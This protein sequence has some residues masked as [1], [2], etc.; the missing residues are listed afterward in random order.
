MRKRVRH[1][2]VLATIASVIGT[3]VSSAVAQT[4]E[5]SVYAADKAG[6]KY[7]PLDQI[8][9]D[10][11][12]DLE[13][14]WRQPV[15]PDEIR[16]GET[17][18]GPVGSQTT[19]LMVDGLLYFS[20]GLGTITAL[21]PTTGEVVW[22]T[23][24]SDGVR[25]RQTRG[26]AYWS[27][28]DERRV[29]A[30][31][32]PKLV[33]LNA[34]TGERDTNFGEAGEVDLREGLLRPFPE[35]Y[36]NSAPTIIRDVIIIGSFIGDILNN[37][38]P[39]TKQAP[40]GD[41]RGYD[42]RTGE[43]LWT[44]YT[45]PRE[46][47]F[48]VDTWGIDPV[49]DRPSWEYSGNTN[50]WAHPTGDEELGIVY[51]PL[52][53][54][55]NDYYGGHR[56]GDNLFAES[57][58]AVDV[59]TGERLWHFQA[60]HHGVWD[61]DFASSAV[62]TDI[63]VNGREIKAV[64][65]P[66]KQAWVYVFDRVT[67]EPVWP[68][69]ERPVP[70]SPVPGERLAETQPFPTKPPAFELQGVTVDDLIDFTPELRAEALEIL[71][72]YEWGPIFTPPVLLDPSPGG[73]KGTI[74]SPGTAGG[75]NW[76]GAGFDPATGM[77]Y[78]PSAY[79]QNVIA[80][81]PSTNPR[82]DVRFV[83]ER[84]EPLPGPQGLPLFKPPY[85]RLTAIDL[86]TGDISWQVPNGIG[87]RNHPA[88]AHLDLPPLGNPGRASV[89]VTGSL[90]FLGEGGNTG[91]SSLPQWYNGP[92]GKMFRAYDKATGDVVW[93]MELPG[94]TSGAPMTYMIDGKQY[95]IATV[96]WDDMGSEL[97]ALTLP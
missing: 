80:I 36:W 51:L 18:R 67:G 39:A 42:V 78:V 37:Q 52:S 64:A 35:Y 32:G 93:E 50:M 23:G 48:G 68:I 30:T 85:G 25:V 87:P 29:V 62:L 9:R 41:V 82:S 2:I 26:V 10:N 94:G 86:N 24:P 91:V 55:S 96:G 89:L 44:F 17:T 20:S 65:Q 66:S 61:Y 49:E 46:N 76:S 14:A 77:L 69:E 56:P 70:A 31:L 88:I 84:Y 43:H 45:I 7:L 58:V 47:E 73:K 19:P 28:G 38:M 27:D 54:P 4:A 71:E 72:R 97:V 83:R 57:L 6:T 12:A 33:S 3:T 63:T 59:E 81:T 75:A 13:I 34:R 16:N 60:I 8:N 21:A 92:G 95:I 90:V 1:A 53:T 22:N 15:I 79:S 5:W 11:V 40:R 74:F